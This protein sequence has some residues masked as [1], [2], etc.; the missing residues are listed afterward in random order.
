MANPR[1]VKATNRTFDIL[2][3][4]NEQNGG[5]LS[6][7]LKEVD[8]AESTLYDHLETLKDNG[9]V[10][11]EGSEY[12]ISL[13][14]LDYGMGAREQKKIVPVSGDSLTQLV[15]KTGGLGLISI[16]EQGWC[17]FLKKEVGEQGVSSIARI[18]R[19]V[20]MHASSSGKA[21]LA[22]YTEQKVDDIL[23]R[24]GLDF[25]T[26]QTIVEKEE[27][28]EELS[29][30]RDSKVAYNDSELVVGSRSVAS[31][32]IHNNRVYGAISIT[33]SRQRIDNERFRNELPELV[34]AAANDIELRLGDH[35]VH[36]TGSG[37]R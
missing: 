24:H 32:I 17:V 30:I 36:I 31:P 11:K 10:V 8:L 5:S 35:N 13:K 18:G 23:E 26:E 25:Y 21:M 16:E 9:F 7:L 6:D 3:V 20:P 37:Q 14:F 33:D 34:S 28:L 1:R 12:K 27:L 19:R 4:V 15:E 29:Q 22:F 2:E